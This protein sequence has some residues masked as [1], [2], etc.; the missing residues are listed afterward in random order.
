MSWP[1]V[2]LTLPRLPLPM[3]LPK[4]G[5]RLLVMAPVVMALSLAISPAFRFF[6]SVTVVTFFS[7]QLL[8]CCCTASASPLPAWMPPVTRTPGVPIWHRFSVVTAK[9]WRPL[10]ASMTA[11]CT[12]RVA[13]SCR[14]VRGLG[15]C[16]WTS[17]RDCRVCVCVCACVRVCVRACVHVCACVCMCVHVCVFFCA[18]GMQAKSAKTT[19]QSKQPIL[20]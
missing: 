10:C 1:L 6:T 4:S 14:V 13:V 8:S 3:F 11:A 18:H 2:T 12:W 5:A 16:L 20:L 7:V 15:T 19:L 9:L 17:V